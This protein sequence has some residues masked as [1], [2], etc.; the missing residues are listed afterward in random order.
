[1]T[2]WALRAVEAL[3]PHT[4]VV[5]QAK[6][7][8]ASASWFVLNRVLGRLGY[9]VGG[10]VID[11]VEYG[12][13]TGRKRSVI[14]A[15]TGRPI[16]WPE[17]VV[18]DRI[19]ADI[20]DP[21]GGDWFDRDRKPWLFNHWDKQKAKGNGF[22]GEAYPITAKRF[23]TIKRRYFAGQ[24]DNPLVAHPTKPGVMR[25]M[26]IDEVKR[27]HGLPTDYYVGDTKTLA[28]EVMGQGVVVSLF[29]RIIESVTGRTRVLGRCKAG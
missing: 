9:N 3:N 25:W 14:V 4:I 6:E 20:L 23:G 8:L 24:G 27:L 21:I 28:G 22:D 19:L 10:R 15:T 13:L 2:F 11:P 29:R 26:T 7:Y 16:V 18:G 12:E 1:M 17:P 5:E